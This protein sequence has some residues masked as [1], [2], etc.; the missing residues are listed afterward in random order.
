LSRRVNDRVGLSCAAID[1]SIGHI[2]VIQSLG[3]ALKPREHLH[4]LMI[5]G[6]YEI[7]PSG[8]ALF[9]PMPAPTDHGRRR[10]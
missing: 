7:A 10:G 1:T 9:H 3:S 8:A 4:T 2:T 6:M 5:D